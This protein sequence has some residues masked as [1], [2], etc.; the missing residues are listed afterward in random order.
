M[1][2]Y[3]TR[4]TKF[5][6]VLYQEQSTTM[7]LEVPNL[8][9][10]FTKFGTVLYQKKGHHIDTKSIKFGTKLYQIWYFWCHSD[11]LFFVQ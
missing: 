5:V 7:T 3:D 9:L 2:H 6:I 10:N 11:A 1:H 8:V 4:S